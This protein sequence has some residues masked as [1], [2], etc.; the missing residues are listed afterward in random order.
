MASQQANILSRRAVDMA[1]HGEAVAQIETK[2]V[3]DAHGNWKRVH[4]IRTRDGDG[5]REEFL[6]DAK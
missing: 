6:G 4:V 5:W 2:A 1:L 3:M